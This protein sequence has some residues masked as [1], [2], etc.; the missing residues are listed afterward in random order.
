LP[1]LPPLQSTRNGDAPS[2][3]PGR[4]EYPPTVAKH[5]REYQNFP[6]H[7]NL[8]ILTPNASPDERFPNFNRDLPSANLNLAD[9]SD[10]YGRLPYEG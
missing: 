10:T 5:F 3:V 1:K 4:L 9:E 6:Q 8:T 7:P 2:C